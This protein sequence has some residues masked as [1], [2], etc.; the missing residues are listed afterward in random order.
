V[1]DLHDTHR[2]NL[3]RTV[4]SNPYQRLDIRL[5]QPVVFYVGASPAKG[6]DKSNGGGAV[7]WDGL[8]L[9]LLWATYWAI[10]TVVGL[11]P[12]LRIKARTIQANTKTE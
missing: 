1:R 8:F 6:P 3:H 11:S 9:A 5:E 7:V 4:N 2:G 12:R 10:G